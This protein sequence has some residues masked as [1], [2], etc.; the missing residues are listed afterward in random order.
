MTTA[1]DAPHA[2][3][4]AWCGREVQPGATPASHGIC[5]PCASAFWRES[6]R[7]PAAV[8]DQE[9]GRS[10]GQVAVLL[11]LLTLVIVALM[12]AMR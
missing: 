6:I 12:V 8:D 5:S 2:V 7:P 3:V 4:C 9:P 10:I 1:V 11:A